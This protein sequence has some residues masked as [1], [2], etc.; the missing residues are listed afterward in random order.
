MEQSERNFRMWERERESEINKVQRGSLEGWKVVQE[1]L[2]RFAEHRGVG[3]HEYV[4]R[5]FRGSSHPDTYQY[6][7]KCCSR[8]RG[9][10]PS[11]RKIGGDEGENIEIILIADCISNA[12]WFNIHKLLNVCRFSSRE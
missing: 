4:A 1:G 11:R 8:V 6:R 3:W 5:V 12:R 7:N 9:V 2:S 10:R